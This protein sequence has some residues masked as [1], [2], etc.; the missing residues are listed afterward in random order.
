MDGYFSQ[1]S[2]DSVRAL[3]YAECIYFLQDEDNSYSGI[4]ESKS[5]IIDIYFIEKSLE[6]VVFRSAVTGTIWP[7]QQKDPGTMRLP[8]FKW[9]EQRRPKTRL[10][11]L[12]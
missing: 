12:E 7:I 2:L 4:N 3:G 10:E 11:L 8:N 9:L 1:G 5:D 6:K